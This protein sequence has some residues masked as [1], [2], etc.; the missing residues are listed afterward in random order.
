MA[1]GLLQ[2]SIQISLDMVVTDGF[3]NNDAVRRELNQKYPTLM[4][5]SNP[6]NVIF[7]GKAHFDIQNPIISSLAAQVS[8]NEKAIFEQIKKASSTK[9]VTISERLEKLKKFNNKNIN[10]DDDNHDDDDDGNSDLPRLPTPPSFPPKNMISIVNLIL[11]T[12]H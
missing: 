12:K 2:D 9:D 4:K 11:M 6:V 8:N 5:K 10:D 3:S 1:T 7:K